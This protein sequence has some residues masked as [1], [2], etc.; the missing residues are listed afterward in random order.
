MRYLLRQFEL[1][2]LL[3]RSVLPYWLAMASCAPD[4]LTASFLVADAL[5][6][7]DK[8]DDGALAAS[9]ETFPAF[10]VIKD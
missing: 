4:N 6:L 3:L 2:V 9:T 1:Y 5:G 10:P 7:S 8:I